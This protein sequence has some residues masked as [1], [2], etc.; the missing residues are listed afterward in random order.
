MAHNNELC[1]ISLN[2]L[3]IRRYIVADM[4]ELATE[5]T[6]TEDSSVIKK[7]GVRKAALPQLSYEGM[8]SHI[9]SLSVGA[10]LVM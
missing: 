3:T 2:V 7:H 9:I 10:I 4:K 1:Y 5:F 8:V 6:S